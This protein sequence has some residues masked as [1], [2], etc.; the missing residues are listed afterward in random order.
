ME[1]WKDIEGYENLYQISDLGNVRSLNAIINCKGAK[2]IN[3][4]IRRGRIL[5]QR[6]TTTGYYYVNLS[7][8]GKVKPS[9]VH[10][11]VA[12]AFIPNDKDF[13]LVNHKDGNKLNNNVNNLEWCDYS[14]N[15]KE[16]YRIGLRKKQKYFGINKSKGE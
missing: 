5:K 15:L 13:N 14:H 6:K 4:H 11:L 16:A 3:T 12:Q 7:K 2:N 1:N 8:N 10:R 9:R